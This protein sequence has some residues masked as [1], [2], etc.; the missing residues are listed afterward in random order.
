MIK[1]FN[2]HSWIITQPETFKNLV[3]RLPP[4]IKH[5]FSY[6]EIGLHPTENGF[7]MSLWVYI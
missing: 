6:L 7:V 3:N 4:I 2:K 1:P 5:N